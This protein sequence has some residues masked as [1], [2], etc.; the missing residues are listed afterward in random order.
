GPGGGSGEEQELQEVQQ[1]V[2]R[3]RTGGSCGV[4]VVF[5]WCG[6]RMVSASV[7]FLESQKRR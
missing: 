6:A 1:K 3:W 7:S 2:I 5:R 4:Q